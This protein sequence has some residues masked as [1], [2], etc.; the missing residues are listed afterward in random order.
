ML[1]VLAASLV[2]IAVAAFDIAIAHP[3]GEAAF[4]AG[5]GGIFTAQAVIA[6]AADFGVGGG[7]RADYWGRG[8][9]RL[10]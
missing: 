6:G 5:G 3:G 2:V 9:L 1:F 8:G 7:Y 4:T 10:G